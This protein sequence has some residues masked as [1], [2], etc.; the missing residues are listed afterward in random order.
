M[1][2]LFRHAHPDVAL[3]APAEP[4]KIVCIGL[5]YADHIREVEKRIG[6]QYNTGTTRS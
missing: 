4:T 2:G 6:A 3:L 5:N 1:G